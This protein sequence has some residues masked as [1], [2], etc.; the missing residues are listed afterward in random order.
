MSQTDRDG[1][2]VTATR[3]HSIYLSD[4]LLNEVHCFPRRS[5]RGG[6][7]DFRP[8]RGPPTHEPPATLLW[9]AAP[10]SQ[11]GQSS[12]CLSTSRTSSAMAWPNGPQRCT[13]SMDGPSRVRV[14]VEV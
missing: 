4:V 13:V 8:L 2:T 9:N 5:V 7:D 6:R 10:T 12:S 3:I 14:A 11:H 1:E